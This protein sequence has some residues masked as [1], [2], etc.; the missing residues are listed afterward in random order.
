MENNNQQ[1]AKS[2]L[3]T[4][5]FF[6][7]QVENVLYDHP[8]VDEAAVFFIQ[9]ESIPKG[10]LVIFIVSHMPELKDT[11]ILDFLKKSN[12]LEPEKVPQY[13]KFVS[14]IPKSPSGKVL[15]YNLLDGNV[16][17]SPSKTEFK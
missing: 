12:Q 10:Q 16:D 15:T 7:R 4:K 5:R 8:G 17:L 9:N 1:Y 13:V 3:F 11:D 6:M 14:R 2:C